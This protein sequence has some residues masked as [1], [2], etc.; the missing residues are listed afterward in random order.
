MKYCFF[1]ALAAVCLMFTACGGA[2]APT[3]ENE[4]IKN[5]QE[6]IDPKTLENDYVYTLP[7]IFHV[8][9]ID[10]NDATQYVS[11]TRLKDILN[12][13][14]DLYAGNVYG[15]SEA[16][17]VKFTLATHDENGRRLETP[18]VEYVQWKEE[19]PIDVNALMTDNKRRYTRYI[20]DP[21]SYINVMVYHFKKNE[22]I[23]G[24]L[25]GI[26]HM[27]YTVKGD[28][29]LAGLDTVTVAQID[30]NA[31]QYAYCLSIN[32]RYIN[33][34]SSRYTTDR[35]RS[36]YQYQP[37]DI[38]VTLA[39]ELGH[40]LGLHHVFAEN[41]SKQT[42]TYAN[43]CFD[44]DYCHDTPSYNRVAYEA[45]IAKYL[46][47]HPDPNSISFEQL[48]RRTQCNGTFFNAE[49]L[50]DYA[51][52]SSFRFT[53]EQKKR[54]RNVLLYSPLI[55]GIKLNRKPIGRSET[56]DKPLNLPIRYVR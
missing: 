11:A 7:V 23:N 54:I 26:S 19:Y 10:P 42:L 22:N 43:A 3:E 28:H 4:I 20:W 56:V 38:N 27:P 53:K 32:S 14:N 35:G 21:N 29:A 17:N 44:S 41:R 55:P 5:P 2:N 49:N 34:E 47:A 37:T 15:P 51:I 9:Y 24:S 46:A 33:S 40:Y 31:L 52:C 6:E 18:G 39:H 36:S 16:V 45:D 12:N 8:L 1:T 48:I 30:K 50:M 13:V 25:L